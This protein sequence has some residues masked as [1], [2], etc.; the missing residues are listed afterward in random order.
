MSKLI[1]GY[2]YPASSSK[3]SGLV[4]YVVGFGGRVEQYKKAINTLNKL[5][6]DVKM[7]EYLREVLTA[8]DPQLLLSI[9][10]D[11]TA[12]IDIMTKNYNDV[13]CAGISLGSF[14]AFNVQKRIQKANVGMYADAG[15]SVAHAIF[16]AR[17]FK[18]IAVTYTK[19]GYTE[20]S[21]AKAWHLIDIKPCDPYKL[22][23]NKSLIIYNGGRDRVVRLKDAKANI[24]AWRAEGTRVKQI[25]K[26]PLGHIATGF[27]FIRNTKKALETAQTFHETSA[28]IK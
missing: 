24:D 27:W 5:G 7:Y 26:P 19:H 16:T 9:I 25:I 18:N 4:C 15:I 2:F 10:D 11:I 20:E 22:A 28:D 1:T 3:K 12:E 14:I 17:V 21:L 23:A 8:G 6:Y 13:I